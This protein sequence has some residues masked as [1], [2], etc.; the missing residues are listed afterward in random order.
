MTVLSAADVA[1]YRD[2]GYLVVPDALSATELETLRAVTDEMLA[3]ARWMTASD[4]VL[5]L[6]TGHKPEAP[7]VRRVKAAAYAHPYYRR[8]LSFPRILDVLTTLL[9]PSVRLLG[10]KVNIKAPRHGTPVE[11]HQDWAYY[12]HT[13]DDLLAIGLPLD[14]MGLENAPLLVVPGSHKGP[15]YDH[16]SGGF[17]CGGI[18]RVA[19]GLDVSRAVAVTAPAGAMTVHHVRM[20]HGSDLNRSDK[21]RR[22]LFHELAAGDAWPLAYPGAADY[23]RLK[24]DMVVGEPS[25]TPRMVALPVRMPLPESPV[26]ADTLYAKQDYLLNPSFARAE[27]AR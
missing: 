20:L 2:R 15:I 13:N 16:T 3:R 14:D 6:D 22:V 26:E 11:W 18:D 27:A 25:L 9:G 23:A 24:A 19:T 1:F 21:P 8:L 5:E 12:P 4:D 17:F 10:G 7:R